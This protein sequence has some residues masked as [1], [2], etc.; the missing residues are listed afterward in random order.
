MLVDLAWDLNSAV[1]LAGYR[2]YY[3][4][5]SG[6]YSTFIEVGTEVLD[7]QITVRDGALVYFAISAFDLAGNESVFSDEL[8]AINKYT[9]FRL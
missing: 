6:I 8:T 7:A 4:L 1:D 2:V 3:G 9:N 5:S